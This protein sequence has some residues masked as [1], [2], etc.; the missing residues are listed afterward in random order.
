MLLSRADLSGDE[1]RQ[2]D[3]ELESPVRV[4]IRVR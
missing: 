1:G 2:E 3:G 4:P